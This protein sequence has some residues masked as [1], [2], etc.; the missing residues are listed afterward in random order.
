MIRAIRIPSSIV[1]LLAAG[2]LVAPGARAQRLAHPGFSCSSAGPSVVEIGRRMSE[3]VEVR[4]RS[5]HFTALTNPITVQDGRGAGTITAMIGRR[6]PAANA[7]GQ[8]VFFWHDNHFLGWSG[9]FES[10]SAVVVG[11]ASGVFR[12]NFDNRKIITY[13]FGSGG[14]FISNGAPPHTGVKVVRL[15]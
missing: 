4:S 13:A 9:N 3:T 8:L 14:Y 10:R 6:W 12:V 11:A 5:V 15:G 1:M 2:L 7:S